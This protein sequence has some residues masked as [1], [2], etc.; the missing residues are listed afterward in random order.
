M[1]KIIKLDVE[2]KSY[3]LDKS[4]NEKVS[5]LDYNNDNLIVHIDDKYCGILEFDMKQVS[6]Q[7]IYSQV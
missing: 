5:H 6:K 4:T 1:I 3:I 7:L 2:G